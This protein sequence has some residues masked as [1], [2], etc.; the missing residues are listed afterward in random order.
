[1]PSPRRIYYRWR[2]FW[3]IAPSY[4]KTVAR[5]EWQ[6][7]FLAIV[8]LAPGVAALVA[9]TNVALIVEDAAATGAPILVT[10]WLLPSFLLH[11]LGAPGVLVG[12]GVVTLLIG[13]LSLTNVYLVSLDRR[14]G[15]IHLLMALGLNRLETFFL[16]LIEAFAAGLLGSGVGVISSFALSVL[17]WPSAE[18]YFQLEASYQMKFEPLFVGVGIGVFAALLFMGTAT[19]MTVASLAHFGQARPSVSAD[20]WLAI[21]SSLWGPVFAGLLT[22]A[23]ALSLNS[24][25]SAWIL[26]GLGLI[27]AGLLTS[28]GWML[29]HFYRQI[30]TPPYWPLWT[31]AIQGL[32][33]HLNYTTGMA[34]SFI[35]GAYGT[36][37]AA[38]TWLESDH[39]AVFPFWVAIVILTATAS[40]VLTIASVA[41][42]E[43]RREF[44]MLT[45]LGAKRSQLRWLILLE[46]TTVAGSAGLLGSLIAVVS[47]LIAGGSGSWLVALGVT[48]FNMLAVVASAWIGALPV[49]RVLAARSPLHLMSREV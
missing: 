14:W 16:L 36:G 30:P 1:M 17:S 34:L 8:G 21:R 32:A 10:D 11:L 7:A 9:W 46:Y 12:T 37:L 47:W 2:R 43:R 28:G 27:L 49:L 42:W 22:F 18:R 25:Q 35:A 45:A 31:M 40:L 39:N 6:L 13:C 20:P 26:S 3:R 4:L 41:A 44:G 48:F 15:E 38:L 5:R 29:T 23:A 19:L 33:R 24:I